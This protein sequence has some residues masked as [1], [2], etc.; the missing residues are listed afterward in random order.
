M[1]KESA[2]VGLVYVLILRNEISS[3]ANDVYQPN[4][5][6]TISQLKKHINT[7]YGE[8][9]A[10]ASIRCS[11]QDI[12]YIEKMWRKKYPAGSF[13]NS[14]DL[15]LPSTEECVKLGGDLDAVIDTVIRRHS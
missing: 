7:V 4:D 9:F 5:C 1:K 15:R 12:R 10:T 13:S 11:E 2:M 14:R 6:P 8:E 3:G